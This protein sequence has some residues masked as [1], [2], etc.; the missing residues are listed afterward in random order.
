MARS[1]IIAAAMAGRHHIASRYAGIMRLSMAS[2]SNSD[3][4]LIIISPLRRAALA[5]GMFSI[6]GSDIV[7]GITLFMASMSI[8]ARWRRGAAIVMAMCRL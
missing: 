7:V 8:A 4:I 2:Q 5:P 3:K 1:A 6:Y